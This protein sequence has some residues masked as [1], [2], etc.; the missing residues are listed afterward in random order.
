MEFTR[1]NYFG[2]AVVADVNSYYRSNI[3]VDLNLLPSNAEVTHSV[4]QGTLTEGAIGYRQF[5]VIAGSSAMANI[6]LSDNNAPPF[7]AII[8]YT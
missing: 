8:K 1:S 2:K 6:R 7:G 5:D 4:K 3:N